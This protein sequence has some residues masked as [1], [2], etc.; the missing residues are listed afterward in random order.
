MPIYADNKHHGL[1]P[2]GAAAV[3]H[4]GAAGVGVAA[5]S[6]VVHPPR[7][8][9]HE[10]AKSGAGREDISQHHS[11]TLEYGFDWA[12]ILLFKVTGIAN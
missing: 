1:E 8:L 2:E 12:L 3:G 7:L 9:E 5:L 11:E 4:V 10:V 6:R